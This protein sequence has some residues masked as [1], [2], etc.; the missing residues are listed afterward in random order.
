[1]SAGNG[2]RS[3]GRPTPQDTLNNSAASIAD[4]L[5]PFKRGRASTDAHLR[6]VL[7]P[8][9]DVL[10]EQRK[11]FSF[12]PTARGWCYVLEGLGLC[13]KGDFPAVQDRITRCRKMGLLPLNITAVDESRV[14][15]GGGAWSH[16][17]SP[18]DFLACQLDGL[19]Y[20]Y[21]ACNTLDVYRFNV[22]VVVEKLDLVGLF[23][24]VLREYQVPIC[25]GRGW[26]DMHLRAGI[27]QRA[28]R[29]S[30]PT[31]VLMFGDH[32]VGGLGITSAFRSN[33]QE[34]LVSAG[35]SAS[36]LD[37]MQIVRAGLNEADIDRLGLTWIDGLETSAG[38]DLANPKHR[39]HF[40]SDVQSYLAG[41]GARK[42]E[43]NAL[44]ARRHE[45]AD[46]LRT[47]LHEFISDDEVEEV[48]RINSE[49]DDKLDGL[50]DLAVK[51]VNSLGESV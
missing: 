9:V 32:D 24:D 48:N 16:E 25:C 2:E 12:A 35:V 13:S 27:L 44:I 15:Q 1:M 22:E 7:Q 37:E 40:N 20:K 21:R 5:I 38:D 4:I 23:D 50:V 33:L 6:Q 11:K 3:T 47:A 39:Q 31:V 28:A 34:C 43:A 49:A 45:A 29:S 18:A 10:F 36:V 26:S 42:V 46:L 51:Y 8:L 41:F 14:Q 19:R 17:E 30:L